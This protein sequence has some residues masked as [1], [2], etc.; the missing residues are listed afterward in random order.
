MLIPREPN[1]EIS[2]ESVLFCINNGESLTATRSAMGG[3]CQARISRF[4]PSKGGKKE[5]ITSVVTM[6]TAEQ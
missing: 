2:N 6:R 3:A 5:Y 1:P 4:L